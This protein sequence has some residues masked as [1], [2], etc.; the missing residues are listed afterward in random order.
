MPDPTSDASKP[1][2]P[3]SVDS[4]SSHAS[5]RHD[6]S[7]PATTTESPHVPNTAATKSGHA[8]PAYAATVE[9]TPRPATGSAHAPATAHLPPT[10]AYVT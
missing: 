5:P 3:Q 9:S 10:R 6:R 7:V 2:S 4:K 8:E 1:S